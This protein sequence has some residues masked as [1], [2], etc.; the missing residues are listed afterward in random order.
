MKKCKGLE[1]S[2]SLV[3][4]A[5]AVAG[6]TPQS[7]QLLVL[8]HDEGFHVCW[9]SLCLTVGAQLAAVGGVPSEVL[10]ASIPADCRICM[11]L[12]GHPLLDVPLHHC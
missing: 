2:Y 1:T 10:R 11:G 9:R 3:Y 8:I 4:K 7:V 6:S 12:A 5:V